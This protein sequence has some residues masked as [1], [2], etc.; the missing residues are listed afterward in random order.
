M[1][2]LRLALQ[3]AL[4]L[5]LWLAPADIDSDAKPHGT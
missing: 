1:L 2:A 5:A 4:R 3:L